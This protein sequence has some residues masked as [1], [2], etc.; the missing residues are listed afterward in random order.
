[1]KGT[2]GGNPYNDLTRNVWPFYAF[3]ECSRNPYNLV[4][5]TMAL[6]ASNSDAVRMGCNFEPQIRKFPT[7]KIFLITNNFLSQTLKFFQL[8]NFFISKPKKFFKP[9]NFFI[10][11]P[12]KFSQSQNFRISRSKKKLR[13]KNFSGSLWFF[14]RGPYFGYY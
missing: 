6:V 3:D 10:S 11:K 14:V 1:M 7:Q 2:H 12:Q 5:S 13:L 4:K 8:Q 9:Q